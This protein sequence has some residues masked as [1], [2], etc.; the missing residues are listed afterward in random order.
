MRMPAMLATRA[1]GALLLLVF[2]AACFAQ[3]AS[4]PLLITTWRLKPDMVEQWSAL[5]KNEVVPALQKAGVKEY[6]VYQTVLGEDLEFL[7][8]RPLAG[9]AEFDKP[10]MLAR[11]L[12]V[13]AAA[14]LAA[15]L[16][17]CSREVRRSIE[18]RQDEFLID[19][20]DAAVQYASKYR[21]MPGRAQ[22]YM[23]FIRTEMFPVMQ[24]AKEAGTFSGLTVTV[25]GHGGEW[26]LITLNMYYPEFAPLDGPPPVAKTLGPE[27]TRQFLAKGAG[28]ITPLEWIVRKRIA[29]LSF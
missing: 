15:K 8:V 4:T 18:N 20:G 2:S 14:K 23:N 7:T 6:D 9:I 16:Q 17:Q 29:E 26:G 10:D 19:P 5:Q 12:G 28:L 22:D 11:V 27:G 3:A 21:A 25:S 1:A 24:K 13:E